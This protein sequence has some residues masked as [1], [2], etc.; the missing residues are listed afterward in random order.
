M[1]E[2]N[3][4]ALSWGGESDPTHVDSGEPDAGAGPDSAALAPGVSS[5]M[6]VVYGVFGGIYLLYTVGWLIIAIRGSQTTGVALGD[7]MQHASTLLA[8]AAAPAW[9][10]ATLSLTP[11]RRSWLRVVVLVIG[12]LVLVPWAFMSGGSQ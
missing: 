4:D 8:V 2:A 6:L 12:V 5:P 7:I 9:F 1:A 3:D 11:G 10:I